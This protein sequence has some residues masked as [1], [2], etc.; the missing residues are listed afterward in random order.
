MANWQILGT[1]AGIIY[2]NN[3]CMWKFN[4]DV[5]CFWFRR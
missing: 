3:T 2:V 1:S 5:I 4:V